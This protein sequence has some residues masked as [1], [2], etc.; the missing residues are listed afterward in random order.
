MPGVPVCE[1]DRQRQKTDR[2]PLSTA[3]QVAGGVLSSLGGLL[4]GLQLP[5]QGNQAFGNV[6]AGIDGRA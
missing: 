2:V 5:H 1:K 4:I 6:G 3:A